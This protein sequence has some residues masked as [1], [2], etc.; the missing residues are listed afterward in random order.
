GHGTGLSIKNNAFID[1]Y[2]DDGRAKDYY[3][4]VEVYKN[5][6]LVTGGRLRVNSPIGYDGVSLHQATY[7]QAA[8]FLVT[9]AATGKVLWNDSIPIF[10]SAN[11]AFARQF[12]DAAGEFEPTG[13][14]PFNDLGLT[15]RLVGSAGQNDEKIGVG[16]VALAVFDNRA[17]KAGSGPIGTGKLSPGGSVTVGGLIF[18]FQ[19]EVRF[20]GLQ[21]TY[22]PGLPVIVAAAALIFFS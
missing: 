21:L 10:V 11:Q 20:T 3:S 19:R 16:Q 9:D 6:T 7:G 1:V 4:D 14:Q 13:V 5:G 2:Y 15:L 12:V 17:V 18:T 8:K 22:N